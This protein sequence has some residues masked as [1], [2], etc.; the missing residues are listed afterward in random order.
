MTHQN[1]FFKLAVSLLLAKIKERF[2]MSQNFISD[3]QS[4]SKIV[5]KR[6]MIYHEVLKSDFFVHYLAFRNML[7]D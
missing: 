5:G 7:I 6:E 2:D 3:T 1:R 4:K